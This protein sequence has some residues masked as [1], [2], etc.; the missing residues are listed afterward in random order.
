MSWGLPFTSAKGPPA[1]AAK[2]SGVLLTGTESRPGTPLS[3]IAATATSARSSLTARI[4]PAGSPVSIERW[5]RG[6]SSA[7]F[8]KNG[9][10]IE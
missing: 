6:Y 8:F 9:G 10:T 5:I 7:S 2:T 4:A 3:G 1:L